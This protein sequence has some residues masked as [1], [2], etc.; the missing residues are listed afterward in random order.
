MYK[1]V[2]AIAEGPDRKT[3]AQGLREI[4]D[5]IERGISGATSSGHDPRWDFE[6]YRSDMQ[7][8]VDLMRAAEAAGRIRAVP[9]Q[10]TKNARQVKAARA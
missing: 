9:H 8:F 7:P 10:P 1:C 3:I 2:V 5:E 4:A 6:L